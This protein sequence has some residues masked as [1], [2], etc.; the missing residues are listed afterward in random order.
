[1]G[2][3]SQLIYGLETHGRSSLVTAPY[4]PAGGAAGLLVEYLVEG[5]DSRVPD[6]EG[7]VER[8]LDTV[9]SHAGRFVAQEHRRL[10]CDNRQERRPLSLL[11][12]QGLCGLFGEGQVL[13]CSR[14]TESSAAPGGEAVS[15]RRGAD[16]R[17]TGGQGRTMHSGAF[18][19]GVRVRPAEPGQCGGADHGP[20]RAGGVLGLSEL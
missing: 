2:V 10:H 12:D 4:G 7:Q 17:E 13:Y 8:V 3:F 19:Q 6:S 14:G 15:A 11:L 9:S 20:D 5:H 16:A 18:A 1:M